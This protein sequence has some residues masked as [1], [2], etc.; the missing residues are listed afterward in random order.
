MP[1]KTPNVHREPEEQSRN[2]KAGYHEKQRLR[3]AREYRADGGI[4][5]G[6]VHEN[7]LEDEVPWK[8]IAAQLLIESFGWNFVDLKL[9]SDIE[10]GRAVGALRERKLFVGG[11]TNIKK[12]NVLSECFRGKRI[13]PR[14]T[15]PRTFEFNRP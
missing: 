7:E 12:V 9:V 3:K 2:E 14:K 11:R 6:V 4:E 8:A 15:H 1:R 5:F 10:V 13:W